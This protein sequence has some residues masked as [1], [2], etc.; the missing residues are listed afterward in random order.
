MTSVLVT[1]G[2]G[3]LGRVLL[4]QLAEAGHDVR[5]TSRTARASGDGVRWLVADLTTG[6]GPA[7][8]VRGAEVVVHL[9]TAPYKGRYTRAVELDGTSALLAAAREA[10]VRHFVYVSIVGVDRVAWGY[11]RTKVHAE[12]LVREGGVPWTIV[13]A[14]Q[15]HEFVD[16][17]LGS[18]ARFGVLIADPGI[19]AQ[20]VDVRD[21]AAH[22]V[23][24]TERGPSG[25]TLGES[26]PDDGVE[27]F[28][29]PQVLTMA[30]LAESWLRARGLR[31]PLLRLRV[32]GALGRAF[33]AG[34]LTT[35][36]RPA[37]AITWAD[38]LS[39]R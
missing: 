15:F 21:L 35:K 14:T 13:R 1:G 38:H 20:P 18:M 4:E 17:T 11:F 9:A 24:L 10:V 2:S 5:A 3:R 16:Q 30:E 26:G 31:R 22:L 7:E 29:G 6:Q 32:P 34:H 19:P 37:G 23:A 33:R 8:A 25:G 12:R 39:G 27:E 28:G 36:A